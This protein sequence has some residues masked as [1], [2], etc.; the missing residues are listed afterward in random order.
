MMRRGSDCIYS[1]LVNLLIRVMKRHCM[2]MIKV[3]CCRMWTHH[4]CLDFKQDQFC[5][6]QGR[7]SIIAFSACRLPSP[8]ILSTDGT[9]FI[10]I[11]GVWPHVRLTVLLQPCQ[12]CT[13][14]R[15]K[16]LKTMKIIPSLM[17]VKALMAI[18]STGKVAFDGF[19]NQSLTYYN[20]GK[21]E[22][23]QD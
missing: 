17:A 8:N 19:S 5:Q 15:R 10:N 21:L 20:I 9:I 22:H 16:H 3:P 14:L 23:S 2:H 18:L 1:V 12:L 11:T 13:Y 4:L 6:Q 7:N